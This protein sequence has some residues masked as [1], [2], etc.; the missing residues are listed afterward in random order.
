MSSLV[1]IIYHEYCHNEADVGGHEHNPDFYE[2]F[3]ALACGKGGFEVARHFLLSGYAKAIADLGKK[4]NANM[5]RELKHE[6]KLGQ[7]DINEH[8]AS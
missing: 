3:H 6:H 2:L 1:S 7:R 4:P 8:Q 5:M